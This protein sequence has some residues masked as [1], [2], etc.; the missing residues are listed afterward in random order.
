MPP[1]SLE[2]WLR[3][4]ATWSGGSGSR[5]TSRGGPAAAAHLRLRGQR[6]PA[7]GRRS[8]WPRP[9]RAEGWSQTTTVV[10]DTFAVLRAGPGLAGGSTAPDG[11]GHPGASRSPAARA[12]TASASARTAGSPGS[13]RSAASPATGAAVTAWAGPLVAGDP[14]RGRPRPG[15]RAARAGAGPLRRCPTVRDVTIAI[16]QG[17]IDRKTRCGAGAGAAG[18]RGRRRPGRPGPGPAAGRGDLRDGAHR[19]APLGLTGQA[20]PVVL[21]GGLLP[22]GDPLLR[23]RW[24]RRLAPE[25]P[26]AVHIVDVPPVVGAALLGLDHTGA[27][28]RR[29]TP[30][31]PTTER[32]SYEESHRPPA[33]AAASAA[34]ASLVLLAGPAGAATG[35]P[36][37]QVAKAAAAPQVRVNQQG[38]APSAPKLAYAM[39]PHQVAAVNFTVRQ[40]PRGVPRPVRALAG[41]W[42]AGYHA[43]YRLSFSGLT[44]PGRYRIT[45]RAG[46][47]TA[48]S[49]SFAIA[50]PS[51]LYHRLVGNAVRYY[52][53]ERDGADVVPSVLNRKP[54]NLTDRHASVFANPRFDG[55]D[56][57]LGTLAQAARRPGQRVRRLVR[58]RRRLREV[59]LHRR[60]HRRPAPARYP[61][62]RRPVPDTGPGGPVRPELAAEAVAPGPQGALHPG[63]HRHGQ[64]E[65]HHPG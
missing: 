63:R 37:R 41:G 1:P 65:Q 28:A 32:R 4:I 53:S 42:N 46:G 9:C 30:C 18:R 51:S 3:V 14:G 11:S 25:A 64:R 26:Q 20:T 31:G 39:L 49:P 33:G 60:L 12:S 34:T 36:S 13:W 17:K 23:L 8:S 47:A 59:R 58:R 27:L 44:R 62:H 38:Y 61:G 45:I 16:H 7:R 5:P 50:S 43:V 22:R 52:A 48:V 40:R 56:N 54:A 57:L 19:D 35:N 21:G 15:H 29:G 2:T 55:D 24:S 6:R 10:N